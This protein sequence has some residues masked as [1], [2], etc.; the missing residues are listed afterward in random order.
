MKVWIFQLL[1]CKSDIYAS[2]FD[3]CTKDIN[4]YLLYA[5]WSVSE[6]LSSNVLQETLITP[7]K[8]N[9][10]R[11]LASAISKDKHDHA[12]QNTCEENVLL[13]W[14][15]AWLIN[16]LIRGWIWGLTW[17]LI[18]CIVVSTFVVC[19][20]SHFERSRNFPQ[21]RAIILWLVRCGKWRLSTANQQKFKRS[22]LLKAGKVIFENQDSQKWNFWL[23]LSL[24][25]MVL[26]WGI[27]VLTVVRCALK[28][29]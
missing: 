25:M 15:N 23:I 5:W 16:G 26:F 14:W 2:S 6:W 13:L 17:E 24:K 19:K 10:C 29:G 21:R 28:Y 4:I 12:K 8:R 3:I 18:W 1:S 22:A 27:T 11:A 7:R 20:K 9:P